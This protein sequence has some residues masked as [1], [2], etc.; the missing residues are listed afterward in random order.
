MGDWNGDGRLSVP[1]LF[2]FI[3]SWFAGD[4]D[5]NNDG[6]ENLQDVF[7]FVNGWFAGS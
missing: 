6:V 4:G 1:D 3:G 7:D 5:A 2:D